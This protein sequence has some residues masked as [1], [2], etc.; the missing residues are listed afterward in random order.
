MV[1]DL[2]NK[3]LNLLHNISM[4]FREMAIYTGYKYF[5]LKYTPAALCL[6]LYYII[7]QQYLIIMLYIVC[8]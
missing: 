8:Y 2:S 1:T 3:H 7:T 4:S 5:L 6:N